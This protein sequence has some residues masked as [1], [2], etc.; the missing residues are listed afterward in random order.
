MGFRLAGRIGIHL[1]HVLYA[2]PHTFA[3]K[4]DTPNSG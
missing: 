3:G 2:V 1:C 4:L